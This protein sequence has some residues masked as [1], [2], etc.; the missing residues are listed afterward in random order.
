MAKVIFSTSGSCLIYSGSTI[1]LTGLTY[2]QAKS[3]IDTTDTGTSG[4]GK[5]YVYSRVERTFTADVMLVSGAA[6]LPLGVLHPCTIKYEG[7]S[8]VGSASLD[9]LS[10][11]G[12][13]DN[14]VKLKIAGR[15]QGSVS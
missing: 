7:K 5:D 14:A 4:D 12:T 2:N 6:D 8:Y 13:I 11:E 9:S 10:T 3:T 1:Y 15:F